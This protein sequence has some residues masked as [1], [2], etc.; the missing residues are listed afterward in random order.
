MALI[1]KTVNLLR[2]LT[3]LTKTFIF[4]VWQGPKFAM[5]LTDLAYDVLEETKYQTSLLD[6]Q[7]DAT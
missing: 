1:V 2:E 5:K 4:N 7:T 3:K 6:H